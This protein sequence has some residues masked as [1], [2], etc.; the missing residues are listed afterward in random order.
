MPAAS[1]GDA[2]ML[3]S[4]DRDLLVQTILGAIPTPLSAQYLVDGVR[5]G[6]WN[7]VVPLGAT[8]AN[9]ITRIVETADGQ[10]WLK[11]LVQRLIE[12][13]PARPEFS[14]VMLSINRAGPMTAPASNAA[15]RSDLPNFSVAN[16]QQLRLLRV[17]LV[18][19]T[20]AAGLDMVL[21]ATR[22]SR[23][24]DLVPPGPFQEQVFELL[25]LARRQGWLDDL[26]QAALTEWPEAPELRRVIQTYSLTATTPTGSTSPQP[27]GDR[28]DPGASLPLERLIGRQIGN[29]EPSAWVEALAKV[30]NR[31]CRLE[32]GS[33][34]YATG[35][36]I[37][38][39]L[40]LTCEHNISQI[41]SGN[42]LVMRFDFALA[43]AEARQGTMY[44]AAA[45][46]NVI[47]QPY[48]NGTG[49]NF[50]LIRLARSAGHELIPDGGPRGW[51]ALDALPN[52]GIAGEAVLVLHHPMAG[53]MKMSLGT[54]MSIDEQRLHH[55]ARTEPGSSGGGCFNMALQL[56]GLHEGKFTRGEPRGPGQDLENVAIRMDVIESYIQANRP[57]LLTGG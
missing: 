10:G 56:T 19:T 44:A 39:D 11:D 40:V 57:G 24:A 41:V 38:P 42:D 33:G 27:K 17:A 1:C 47:S 55:N 43:G 36:L 14:V 23:L 7:A 48:A 51:I 16:G 35:C 15:P 4:Q 21:S 22:D 12:K 45:D 2:L 6:I 20:N 32:L 25:D 9:A 5:P 8:F 26:V 52:Q 31:V 13:F 3:P 29:L 37:G 28:T 18:K 49:L 34:G 30:R 50:A 46:W 54:L 53:P